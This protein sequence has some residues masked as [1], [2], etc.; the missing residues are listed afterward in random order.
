MGARKYFGVGK[1]PASPRALASP[2]RGSKGVSPAGEVIEGIERSSPSN[3][4]PSGQGLRGVRHWTARNCTVPLC[5]RR[6]VSSVALAEEDAAR[7]GGQGGSEAPL[8]AVLLRH[9]SL[10]RRQYGLFPFH[11]A[12][13]GRRAGSPTV[14]RLEA[15][16]RQGPARDVPGARRPDLPQAH[17]PLRPASSL[18][19]V[20]L[21]L[22]VTVFN[23]A[24]L[25]TEGPLQ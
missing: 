17:I 15:T 9:P 7:K 8:R 19:Q 24:H 18:D 4:T 25:R 20:A 6:P 14:R 10:S 16:R 12:I 22:S 1:S 2:A 5:A 21:I 23:F 13:E 3:A 11:R